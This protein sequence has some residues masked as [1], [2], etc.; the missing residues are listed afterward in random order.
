M[1][2]LALL[3]IT[4]LAWHSGPLASIISLQTLQDVLDILGYPAVVLFIM[5][6]SA[7]VPFPGET[8]L[9]LASFYSAVDGQLQLPIIISCAAFGAIVGDNLGYF[10]GR[11]GGRALIDRYG[12]Y[13]FLKPRHIARAERFFE[14]YG[15]Q[16]VFFGRFISI[17]R[18]W[19]AFLAGVNH[20][21]W[22]NF[23]IYNAAGGISWAIVYGLIGYFAGRIFQYDFGAVER[24]ARN[25]SWGFAILVV[26]AAIVIFLFIRRRRKQRKQAPKNTDVKKEEQPSLPSGTRP[27]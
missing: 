10:A 2:W 26:I 15:D 9:L 27:D 11:T 24:L 21:H 4:A 7:G 8:M 23:L 12:K 18:T 20:M 3:L 19:S 16:T 14:K 5:I 25:I 6:E 17:L 22:R 13:L 1:R